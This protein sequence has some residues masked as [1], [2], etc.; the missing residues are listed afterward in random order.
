VLR[1]TAWKV[2]DELGWSA[3]YKAD[4]IALT[5]LQADAFVTLDADLA[6]RVAGDRQDGD[7]RCLAIERSCPTGRLDGRMV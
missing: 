6:R 4:Y 2:A 7:D 5:V 1:R 3:T